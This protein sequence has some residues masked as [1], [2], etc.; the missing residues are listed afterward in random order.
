MRQANEDL[1][2]A[3]DRQA[4]RHGFRSRFVKVGPFT[5]RLRTDS[6]AD[7]LALETAFDPSPVRA[8]DKPDL[9]VYVAC[10][11]DRSACV[12]R[13][14]LEPLVST[15]PSGLKGLADRAAAPC[16]VMHDRPHQLLKLFDAKS[17]NAVLFIGD[18]DLLPGWER[19]SPLKEFIHLLALSHD[20]LLLHAGSVVD[21]ESHR[22]VLLVGP[23]GA[24]KSSLTAFAVHQGMRTHGDDYVLVDLRAA[25]P[26]CWAIYRTLKLHPSSPAAGLTRGLERWQV[27]AL[28]QKTVYLGAGDGSDASAASGDSFAAQTDIAGICGLTQ[29]ASTSGMDDRA[30]VDPNKNPYVYCYMSTIQQIPYWVGSTLQLTKQLH[31]AVGYWALSV[32]DGVGG[33]TDALRRI[34]A[35]L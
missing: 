19:F 14:V 3:L 9:T 4:A 7:Q 1:S 10:A 34:R 25:Q 6:N 16:V 31:Q 28:S 24:G 12:L 27:D 23:G 26:R 22:S 15:A 32:D 5:I 33:M 30:R 13:S 21:K 11:S 17:A 8:Q 2:A 20:C 18:P 35:L 29:R